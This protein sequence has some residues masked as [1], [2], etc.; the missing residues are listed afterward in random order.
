MRSVLA[1]LGVGDAL[2]KHD[3]LDFVD[4]R[5]R[6]LELELPDGAARVVD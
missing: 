5:I 6:V 2:G 1:D 4:G 3:S